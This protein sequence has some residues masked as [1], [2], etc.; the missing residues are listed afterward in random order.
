MQLTLETLQKI[1]G[2]YIMF[3]KLDDSEIEL[4]TSEDETLPKNY[5]ASALAGFDVYGP[6]IMCEAKDFNF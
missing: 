2:G 3:R 1:C 4:V 5:T 6:A